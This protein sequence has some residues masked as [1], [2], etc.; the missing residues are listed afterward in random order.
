MRGFWWINSRT[1]GSAA[2][3][4]RPTTFILTATFDSRFYEYMLG[5]VAIKAL[6]KYSV[7]VKV[8]VRDSGCKHTLFR[9]FSIGG[10]Y[11]YQSRMIERCLGTYEQH[12]H[13]TL[14]TSAC[15]ER[16]ARKLQIL[17]LKSLV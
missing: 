4:Q 17:F 11:N 3:P 9:P 6:E 12:I 15:A 14:R 2:S 1:A 16:L 5:V 7:H 10:N 13:K 8:K